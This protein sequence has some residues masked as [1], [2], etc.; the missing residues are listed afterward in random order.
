MRGGIQCTV[1]SDPSIFKGY[2]ASTTVTS[3]SSKVGHCGTVSIPIQSTLPAVLI[4][5]WEGF[6]L[7]YQG[8][9]FWHTF[10]PLNNIHVL[11]YL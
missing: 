1:Q 4:T 11:F 3:L 8:L 7:W 2:S 6:L 9:A 5:M 10:A